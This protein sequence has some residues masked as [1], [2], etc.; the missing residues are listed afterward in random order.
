[1]YGNESKAELPPLYYNLKRPWRDLNFNITRSYP[2]LKFFS[3]V[4]QHGSHH[5]GP[6]GEDQGVGL[7]TSW[8]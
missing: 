5:S 2:N 3:I 1:M 8:G 7:L 6:P 4:S